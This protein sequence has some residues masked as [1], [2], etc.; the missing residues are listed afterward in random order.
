MATILPVR[1]CDLLK[2]G[3]LRILGQLFSAQQER[4]SSIPMHG[5]NGLIISVAVVD[6]ANK[7]G[8]LG[9]SELRHLHKRIVC[10][11]QLQSFHLRQGDPSNKAPK[12]WLSSFYPWVGELPTWNKVQHLHGL[13]IE[14]PAWFTHCRVAC[15]KRIK[16]PHGCVGF[17]LRDPFLRLG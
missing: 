13:L 1:T 2:G 9:A 4:A 12:L 10:Q 5:L 8:K 3:K 11:P 7:H 14:L 15:R 17:L 16:K 6:S